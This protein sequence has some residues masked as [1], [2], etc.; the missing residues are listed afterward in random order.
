MLTNIKKVKKGD[1][2]LEDLY[3]VTLIVNCILLAMGFRLHS[4]FDFLPSF[5]PIYNLN[6]LPYS[7]A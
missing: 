2:N 3:G 5:L 1:G 7:Q 6:P 4:T